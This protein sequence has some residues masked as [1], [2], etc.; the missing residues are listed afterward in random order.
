MLAR[1]IAEEN[2]RELNK[3]LQRSENCEDAEKQC[4]NLYAREGPERPGGL[5]SR[6]TSHY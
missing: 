1:L 4:L 6:Y 5:F 3:L 2:T